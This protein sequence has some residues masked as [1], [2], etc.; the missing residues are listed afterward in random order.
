MRNVYLE[1]TIPSHLAAYPSRDIIIAA[2]QQIT[3]EW[4]RTARNRFNLF[5]SEAVLAE[6]RSGDPNAILRRLEVVKDLTILKLTDDVRFLAQLYEKELGLSGRAK[7]DIPHFAF[8][9][10]Y[11]IDY[12]ITWNCNHIANGE[13]IRRLIEVNSN[14]N[15]FTPIILTPEE[16]LDSSEG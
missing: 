7:S 14:I 6:I 13:V 16:I 9:V 3:H 8:A 12:L 11:K 1:T 5:I 2:H 4:W 15:R 10:S